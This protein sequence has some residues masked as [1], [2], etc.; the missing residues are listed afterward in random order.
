MQ[1]GAATKS[2]HAMQL[3]QATGRLIGTRVFESS[4]TY[5]PTP[6]T[7]FVIVECQGGGASGAGATVPSSGN[8]SVG[9]PG[10]AG[11]YVRG[12]FTAAQIG[13]SKVVT[14]GA[15]GLAQVGGGGL[16]GG[17]T[18]L[19]SLISAAGGVGGTVLNNQAPPI[20]NGNGNFAS[21]VVGGNINSTAGSCSSLSLGLSSLSG[22]GASGGRSQFGDGGYP[23]STNSTGVSAINPGSGG[24][25]AVATSASG[26]SISGGYGA[27][28]IM[29]IWEYA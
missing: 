6:G 13:A 29:L 17:I 1:V 27:S 20:V 7:G 22:T 5:T 18:S 10:T 21:T 25:G 24:S 12:K 9:A 14:I 26:G 4:T 2:S 28:G 3:G 8:I 15:G 16:S 23:V 11:A 19:G